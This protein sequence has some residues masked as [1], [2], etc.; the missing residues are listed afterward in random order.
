MYE[1]Y[2]DM[3]FLD[4]W[5]TMRIEVKDKAAKLFLNNSKHPILIVKDLKLGENTEGVKN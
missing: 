4:E 1:S 5:I 3:G 2:A